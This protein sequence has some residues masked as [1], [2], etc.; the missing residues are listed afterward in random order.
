MIFEGYEREMVRDGTT[1]IA[2]VKHHLDLI[3]AKALGKEESSDFMQRTHSTLP[4]LAL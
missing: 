2:R 3:R 1:E 4:E